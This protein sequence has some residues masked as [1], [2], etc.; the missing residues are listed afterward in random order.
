M[1]GTHFFGLPL[2]LHVGGV[3]NKKPVRGTWGC[4]SALFFSLNQHFIKSRAILS[5]TA[6]ASEKAYSIYK[7][8]SLCFVAKEIGVKCAK[9]LYS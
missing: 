1:R 4:V 8:Y 7:V 2:S 6:I 3:Q 9:S 5:F